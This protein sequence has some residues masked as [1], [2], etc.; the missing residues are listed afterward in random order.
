MLPTGAGDLAAG[1]STNASTRVAES[2]QATRADVLAFTTFSAANWRTIWSSNPLERLN[3]EA[4]GAARRSGSS[5]TASL[6]S[7]SSA[8]PLMTGTTN[9]PIAQR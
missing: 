2:M 6:R 9:G 8:P 1:A 5:P 3:K 4:S 7:A